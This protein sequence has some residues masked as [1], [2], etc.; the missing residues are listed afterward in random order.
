MPGDFKWTVPRKV[1]W[2]VVYT[3]LERLISNFKFSVNFKKLLYAYMENTINDEKSIKIEHDS[4]KMDQFEKK[5]RSSLY[6][7]DTVGS[8]KPKNHLTLL[9]L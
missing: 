8:M 1:L 5:F 9:S 4:V 6:I 7:L 3:G 2:R